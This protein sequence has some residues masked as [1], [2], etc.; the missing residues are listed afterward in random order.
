MSR[1]SSTPKSPV[2]AAIIDMR[3]RMQITQ[4]ELAHALQVALPTIGRWESWDPPKG[5]ALDKLATFA[6]RNNLK[7]PLNVFKRALAKTPTK[8]YPLWI[9]LDSAEEWHYVRAV[10]TVLREPSPFFSS[11]P[12]LDEVLA[13]VIRANEAMRREGKRALEDLQ[14][15][16]RERRRKEKPKK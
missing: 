9:A 16:S 4:A 1:P 6:E 3:R 5:S 8:D 2:S 14:A 7:Q 12:K 15:V 10:Q 11:R 13:P